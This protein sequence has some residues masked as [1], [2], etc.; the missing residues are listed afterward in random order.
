MSD[1]ETNRARS[2]LDE[3]TRAFLEKGG[4]I[5]KVPTGKSGWDPDRKKSQWSKAQP[6]PPAS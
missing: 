3:Q 5:T 6:K 4:A 2:Q 1:F